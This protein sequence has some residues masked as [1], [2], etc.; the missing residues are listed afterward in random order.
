[1]RISG[2][3]KEVN[4]NIDNLYIYMLVYSIFSSISINKNK[5]FTNPAKKFTIKIDV[6]LQFM[7]QLLILKRITS[8][9]ILLDDIQGF[10]CLKL[11]VMVTIFENE[12]YFWIEN[13]K[14]FELL[15]GDLV[16]S[17]YW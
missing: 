12:I 6:K 16:C 4:N 3:I 13:N 14:R 5:K 9:R 1:M 8:N 10:K 7:Y 11:W 2:L 15:H 17:S